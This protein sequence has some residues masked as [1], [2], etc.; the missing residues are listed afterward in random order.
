MSIWIRTAR[1]PSLDRRQLSRREAKPLLEPNEHPELA[2]PQTIL[3]QTESV[4]RPIALGP[5]TCLCR[6]NPIHYP[7]P[8]AEDNRSMLL[9]SVFGSHEAY[10]ISFGRS[11]H[12]RRNS[13][14]CGCPIFRGVF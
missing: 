4:D 3:R 14:L 2:I 8:P 11:C 13:I 6:R 9:A 5:Y 10:R 1:I 7:D 12:V